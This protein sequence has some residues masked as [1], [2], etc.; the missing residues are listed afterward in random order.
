MFL[1]VVT[2]TYKRPTWLGFNQASLRIQTDTDW[3]QT[4]LVDEAGI[5]CAAAN[6]R[7][8]D[9]EPAGDYVWVLDDDDYCVAPK[10]VETLRR[11][12][13]MHAQ[14]PAILMRTIDEAFG[15]LPPDLLWQKP[16]VYASIGSSNIFTRADVWMRHRAAWATG[17]YAA[18]YDFIESV[19]TEHSFGIIWHDLIVRS[20]MRISRGEPETIYE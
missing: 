17:R 11:V 15:V 10:M 7:L 13:V 2:R 3:K 16:P 5:G 19:W 18:D 9:F 12:T 1:E 20:A 8:A 4:L 14:P 6:A